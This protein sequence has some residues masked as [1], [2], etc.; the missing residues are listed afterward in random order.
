VFT[1]TA[2]DAAGGPLA[3][4]CAPGSG[5]IFPLGTTLVEC[6]ASDAYGNEASA[7]FT[8]TIADTTPPSL[9][10]PAPVTV[11]TRDPAGAPVSYPAP[12]ATDVV[13]AAPGISCTPASGT[14]FAVGTTQVECTARDAS[15]NSALGAFSVIVT[16]VAPAGPDGRMIGAGR[17]DEGRLR[18]R[19]VF[20]V[21]ERNDTAYGRFEFW[22]IE[23]R[24]DQDDD[25]ACDGGRDRDYGHQR[26]GVKSRFESTSIARVAFS[27][28]PALE[29]GRGRRHP[30][31]DSVLFAGAGRWNGKA[32]YTFEVL[33]TDAGEPGRHRDA[34]SLV[35]RDARG[36]VVAAVGGSIDGG[37]IESTRL[38]R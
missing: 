31:V 15:G 11:E 32:G 27:D 10:V 2:A 36:V 35:V 34:F 20:R 8:V 7:S 25:G 6:T 12:T 19:F 22:S 21:A 9:S 23:R 33:A 24:H 1:A 4:V 30:A 3:P 5:S 18:S 26:R 13:D 17:I 16:L 28:D 38:R 14:R 29:P 37:N